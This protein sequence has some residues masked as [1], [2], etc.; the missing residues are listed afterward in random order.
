MRIWYE[1]TYR[2]EVTETRDLP[3]MLGSS[4]ESFPMGEIL[5][6]LLQIVM[7]IDQWNLYYSDIT[8]MTDL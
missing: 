3:T 7:I 8:R 6:K 2:L 4:N 1:S 5:R